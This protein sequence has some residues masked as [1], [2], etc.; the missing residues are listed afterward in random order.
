[1]QGVPP[2][3][4][5]VLFIHPN[6]PAQFV[7]HAAALAADPAHRV[8]ALSMH[9]APAPAGVEVCSYRPATGQ[10]SPQLAHA[11]GCA[12]AC[13]ALKAEGFVPDAV[14]AHT[15]WGD[16]MFVK[17]VFPAARLIAYAEFF[18]DPDGPDATFDPAAPPMTAALRAALAAR[19]APVLHTLERA[20]VAI[21]PTAWQR[22]LFPAPLR[23]RM[24]VLHDGI[25]L[26]RLVHRPDIS[27]TLSTNSGELTL[28]PGDE[29]LTY[30]ARNLEPVRGFPTFMRALPAVLRAR[31]RARV[32]IAGGDGNSYSYPAPAGKSWRAALLEEVGGQLD[33]GRVHFTGVLPY[34]HYAA[35]L[36]VSKVHAYLT[37]PFVLSWSFLEAAMSGLP[38]VASATAPVL[39]FAGRLGVGT[40]G[41]FDHG[42]LADALVERLAR[43]A[44]PHV[45][46][47]LEELDSRFC[48]AAFARLLR[49]WGE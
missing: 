17:D 1:M 19:N 11:H 27:L 7:H 44:Q 30:V 38:V 40:V 26:Q 46:R 20:D 6:F 4:M 36:A 15:G 45:P 8:V 5:N 12:A 24:Q 39:E 13:A 29:M 2:K 32:V 18:Y 21:S 35:L 16:A 47:T 3:R 37:T 28:R 31:P 43:P 14:A 23:E 41:F 10:A 9:G 25:D 49:P 34:R 33:L 42:A 22:S 48:A